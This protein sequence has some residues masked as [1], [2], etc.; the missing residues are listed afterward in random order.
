[1]RI[2]FGNLR[3]AVPSRLPAC[4]L[5]LEDHVALLDRSAEFNVK[6]PIPAVY[7]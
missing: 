3:R 4:A 1:M 5:Q 2:D 6:L 7:L